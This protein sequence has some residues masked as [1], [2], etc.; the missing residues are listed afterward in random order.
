PGRGT[1]VSGITLGFVQDR[2]W[3][4]CFIVQL[5]RKRGAARFTFARRLYSETWKAAVDAWA[6][7]YTILPDDYERVLNNPPPPEQFKELRRIMNAEGFEIPVTAL[8]PVFTEQ[9][10]KIRKMKPL[11]L[12]PYK[13]CSIELGNSN[14]KTMEKEITAWFQSERSW[15]EKV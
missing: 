5:S 13:P 11:A 15:S 7:N 1:G 12:K 3:I 8:R 2:T 10:E 9:R 6:E 14:S 4:P